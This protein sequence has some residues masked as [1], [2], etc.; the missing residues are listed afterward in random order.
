M[1]RPVSDDSGGEGGERVRTWRSRAASEIE[2]W[3]DKF[4]G[5]GGLKVFAARG[6]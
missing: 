5:S 2:R 6:K 1:E 4:E 3:N